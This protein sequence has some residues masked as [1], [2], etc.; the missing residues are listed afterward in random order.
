[1]NFISISKQKI[2]LKLFLSKKLYAESNN[3]K[4]YE[5]GEIV[6]MSGS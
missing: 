1:M 2:E 3:F 6:L 5:S 4:I